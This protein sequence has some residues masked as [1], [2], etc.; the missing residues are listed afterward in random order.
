MIFSKPKALKYNLIFGYKNNFVHVKNF[1][2]IQNQFESRFPRGSQPTTQNMNDL[3]K[4]H[5]RGSVEER[6]P[7]NSKI[8]TKF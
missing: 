4:I 6:K 7:I 3:K 8:I 1:K 5:I 2:K